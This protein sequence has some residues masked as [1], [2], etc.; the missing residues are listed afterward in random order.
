M[1]LDLCVEAESLKDSTDWKNTTDKLIRLQKQWKTIGPVPRRNSDKI[2]KRFRAACDVFFEN[3]SAHFKGRKDE[4]KN[5]FEAKKAIVD[6][7]VAF[8]PTKD[9]AKNLD[10]LKGF[11]RSWFEIGHVPFDKKDKLQSAYCEAVDALLDKMQITKSE[12][13]QEDFKEKVELMKSSPD[14][15]RIIFKEKSFLRN[16]INKLQEDVTL[17]ENNIG[18]FSITNKSNTFKDEFQKKIDKAKKEI[19]LIKTKLRML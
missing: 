19:E 15:D 1:K 4:E 3:K 6:A 12:L 8:E 10:T 11:Q 17:W 13:S 2:W 9:K 7:I 16:K 18:F 5:N 14:S